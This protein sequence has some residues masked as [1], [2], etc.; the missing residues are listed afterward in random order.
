[1]ADFR[2]YTILLHFK[3]AKYRILFATESNIFLKNNKEYE[4]F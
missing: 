4:Y 3:I 1:M 2:L